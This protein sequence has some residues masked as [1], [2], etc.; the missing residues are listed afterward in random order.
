MILL[1]V[2][3]AIIAAGIS[4]IIYWNTKNKY[5]ERSRTPEW[6]TTKYY[7]VVYDDDDMTEMMA[8]YDGNDAKV[9]AML[10]CLLTRLIVDTGIQGWF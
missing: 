8:S 7:K 10:S 4:L 2:M 9:A 3:M 5:V 1:I 6:N